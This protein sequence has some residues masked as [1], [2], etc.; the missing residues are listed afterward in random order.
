MNEPTHTLTDE[1]RSAKLEALFG[2]RYTGHGSLFT[3]STAIYNNLHTDEELNKLL[4]EMC[5]FTGIKPNGLHAELTNDTNQ[6][7]SVDIAAKKIYIAK[8]YRL[9]P[10]ALGALLALAVVSYAVQRHDK[11]PATQSF[12]SYASVH[13]GLGLWIIN[14]LKP[15]IRLHAKIYHLIDMSW[16]QAEGITPPGYTNL[17]YMQQFTAYTQ[18]HKI[19][20]ESYLPYIL[21]RSRHLLPSAITAKSARYLPHSQTTARHLR[22]AKLLWVKIILIGLIIA[23]GSAISLYL[24][25]QNNTSSRDSSPEMNTITQLRDSFNAC[26]DEATLLLSTT[27]PNDIFAARQADAIKSRCESLRNQYNSAVDSYNEQY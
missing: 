1:D 13:L 18:N 22:A 27:D 5:R 19:A 6:A 7:Y 24:V 25:T 8:Q 26:Q 4:K 11:A 23:A 17:Q 16:V 20:A 12:V 3:P 21:K 15:A 10:Y 14:G 2:H 9:H